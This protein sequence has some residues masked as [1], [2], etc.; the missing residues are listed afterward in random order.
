MKNGNLTQFLDTGW[1]TEAVLYFDG[2]VYWCEGATDFETGI[3]TFF[4]DSW[5]AECRK[6][7]Y[8]QR[9]DQRKTEGRELPFHYADAKSRDCQEIRQGYR[10]RGYSRADRRRGRRGGTRP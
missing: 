1:Y 4:V 9:C 6:E 7:F 5:K 3:T 2:H 10:A 8:P